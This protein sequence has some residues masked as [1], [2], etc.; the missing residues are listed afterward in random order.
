[1]QRIAV[2]LCAGVLYAL[3]MLVIW[4]LGTS[5]AEEKTETQLDFAIQDY[6]SSVAGAIDTMLGY[7]GKSAVRELREPKAYSREHMLALARSLDIDEINVVNRNGTIIASTDPVC[8]GVEM[9]GDRVMDEFMRLTNGVTESVSQPFRSHARNREVRAKYLAVAFPGGNG[10]VQVGMNERHLSTMLPLMLGYLF[11]NYRFGSKGFFLCANDTTDALVLNPSRH[12]GKAKTLAQAGFDHAEAKQYEII[13]QKDLG[14]TFTQTL[15]GEKCYCRNYHFGAHRFIPALPESEYYD[16]RAMFVGVFGSLL[17]IVILGGAFITDRILSDASR[18]KMFYRAEDERRAKDMEIAKTIQL[19]ALPNAMPESPYFRLHATM[20]AAREVGGDFFDFFAINSSH[21]AFL[22]A[23]VSGKGITAA[24]Y[25][26]TAKTLI[27]DCLIAE[28]DPAAALT[29][30]NAELA[31]NNAANMFLTAWVGVLDL[32]TGVVTYANAGHNPPL[33]LSKNGGAKYLPAKSGPVIAFMEGVKYVP[34]T[35]SL[36]PGE[37]LFLYTDGV[38]EALDRKNT[39]FGE[40]RLL[41]TIDSAPVDAPRETCEIVRNAVGRFANGAPQADDIT[42]LGIAYISRPRMFSRSFPPVQSG[43]SDAAAWLDSLD[44]EC[45]TPGLLSTLHIILDEICSNI[46]RHSGASGFEVDVEELEN[47]QGVK[48]V[49]IDDGVAYDPL[50]H[51]DPDT[52]LSAEERPIGG[53][54]ILMV[55][56]MSDSVSYMR[57]H[58]RNFLTVVKK[59]TK[60]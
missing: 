47:A 7:I 53:L 51:A 34:K 2:Y 50:A 56:K 18:L 39:L 37:S 24:L 15:Y 29:K 43:I 21:I 38:T 58:Y 31:R 32:E 36:E 60:A 17:F 9:A 20:Q 59:A 30:V 52:T 35:I 55:K 42:V 4:L 6:R 40:D 1:M 26:M 10:F 41:E 54:G 16:A 33:K 45:L 14:S 28:R 22:V 11:K 48:I 25:M 8:M 5:Q 12:V 46:V 13:G 57:S 27:K 49:F 23:D 44:I 3:L 19:A